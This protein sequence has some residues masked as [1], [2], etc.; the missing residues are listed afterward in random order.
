MAGVSSQS[1]HG[2]NCSKLKAIEPSYDN[3]NTERD[4][5]KALEPPRYSGSTQPT[6]TG[7][8]DYY[9]VVGAGIS[10]NIKEVSTRAKRKQWLVSRN[11]RE[12]M[13]EQDLAELDAEI[14]LTKEASNVLLN[15]DSR[16]VA[17]C[18]F[19]NQHSILV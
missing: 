9:A 14:A 16:H 12:G 6:R 4:M 7:F 15:K 2:I 5:R 11:N 19:H 17:I 3:Q 8:K 13:S 1:I 10:L 18:L